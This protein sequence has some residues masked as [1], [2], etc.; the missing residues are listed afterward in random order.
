MNDLPSEILDELEKMKNQRFVHKFSKETLDNIFI[1]WLIEDSEFE[2]TISKIS[3]NYMLSKFMLL[4]LAHVNENLQKK[5]NI[6]TITSKEFS[7]LEKEDFDYVVD[8]IKDDYLVQWLK[9]KC[10]PELKRILEELEIKNLEEVVELGITEEILITALNQGKKNDKDGYFFE[11]LY[12][13]DDRL[14]EDNF[15]KK[16]FAVNVTLEVIEATVDA[17]NRIIYSKSKEVLPIAT[18]NKDAAKQLLLPGD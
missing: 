16:K 15:L 12:Q 13:L 5:H 17:N 11:I 8:K 4:Y 18:S 14:K 3:A 7:K 9:V 2:K 1:T 10:A 6:P